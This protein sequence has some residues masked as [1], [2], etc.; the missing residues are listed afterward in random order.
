M[1][2]EAA[3]TLGAWNIEAEDPEALGTFWGEVF[4]VSPRLYAGM[5]Y[6]PGAGPGGVPV[7]VQPLTAPRADRQ[8]GH[9]DLTVPYGTREAEVARLVRLGAQHRWDVLDEHPHV[10]WSTLAD[11]EGNL[12]CLAEHPPTA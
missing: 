7:M 9:L 1:E 8:M 11:P 10:R 4:G 2:T 12:F 3:I 5:A 6:V